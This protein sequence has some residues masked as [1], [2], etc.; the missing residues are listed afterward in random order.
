[1]TMKVVKTI[2]LVL[3]AAMTLP[4]M[5]QTNKDPQ[6]KKD[7]SRAKVEVVNGQNLLVLKK[8][9]KVQSSNWGTSYSADIVL[10][11]DDNTWHQLE[12][13]I[14]SPFGKIIKVKDLHGYN[15]EITKAN[16]NSHVGLMFISGTKCVAITEEEFR[17][18]K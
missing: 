9:W 6:I 11:L 8:G 7:D 13:L 18:L 15:V 3:L 17:K 1:M 10:K 12:S 4:L 14:S 2:I 5:A 16:V